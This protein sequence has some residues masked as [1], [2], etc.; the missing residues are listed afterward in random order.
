MPRAV[1]KDKDGYGERLQQGVH[2][3]R[4]VGEE[5]EWILPWKE[6]LLRVTGVG[7]SHVKGRLGCGRTED[8]SVGDGKHSGLAWPGKTRGPGLCVEALRFA[9]EVFHPREGCEQID[10]LQRPP[11]LQCVHS[12]SFQIG[13]NV[14][15]LLLLLES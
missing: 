2:V 14:P 12:T 3:F 1:G 7:E 15:P 11:W 5:E 4:E 10:A 8:Q 9:T 13:Y 6:E